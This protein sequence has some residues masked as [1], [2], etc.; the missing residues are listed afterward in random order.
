MHLCAEAKIHRL[1]QYFNAFRNRLDPAA[2]V[3][4]LWMVSHHERPELLILG[5]DVAATFEKLRCWKGDLAKHA[6]VFHEVFCPIPGGEYDM[7][8][9]E[10]LNLPFEQL[11]TRSKL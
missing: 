8:W 10:R 7:L 9:A 3:F 11:P 1:G 5:Q 4:T 6:I 2:L